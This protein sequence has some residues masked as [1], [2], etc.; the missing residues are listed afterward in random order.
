[1]IYQKIDLPVIT[2]NS[3][4]S[5]SNRLAYVGSDYYKGGATAAGLMKFLIKPN[6]DIA[7]ITG[8]LN[9]L[10]HRLRVDGFTD[11]I[12][13][14][15]EGIRIVD[16]IECNDD[17]YEAYEATKALFQKYPDIKSIFIGAGGT[18]GVCEAVKHLEL[19]SN[20]KIICFDLTLPIRAC[21]REGII[22][23]A[24][25]QEPEYQGRKP[26]E[27][28][29]EYLVNEVQPRKDCY[30]TKTEIYIHENTEI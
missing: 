10:G 17:N 2:T 12:T 23:F 18:E 28:L 19:S 16:V 5:N 22:D 27:L 20:V 21:M 4:I 8:S 13:K 1:M 25:L 14:A 24:I 9:M 6:E 30:Y 7:V 11:K 29:F 15:V 3:D 26:V